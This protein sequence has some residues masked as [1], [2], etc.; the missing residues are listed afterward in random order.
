MEVDNL[1]VKHCGGSLLPEAVGAYVS[2]QLC[3][4]CYLSQIHP[5]ISRPVSVTPISPA[6]LGPSVNVSYV[7]IWIPLPSRSHPGTLPPLHSY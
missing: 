3:R 6:P 5:Q 2:P 4:Y 7:N 1:Y